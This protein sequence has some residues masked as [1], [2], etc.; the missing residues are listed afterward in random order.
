MLAVERLL[1]AALQQQAPEQCSGSLD[2]RRGLA[3]PALA[4]RGAAASAEPRASLR[5]GMNSSSDRELDG[6]PPTL[7]VLVDLELTP[8]LESWSQKLGCRL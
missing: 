6:E 4:W 7:W 8:P 5:A 3:A 1:P 2:V